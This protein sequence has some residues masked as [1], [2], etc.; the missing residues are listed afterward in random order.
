MNSKNLCFLCVVLISAS[1][2]C[3]DNDDRPDPIVPNK[4]EIL[5]ATEVTTQSAVLNGTI[6]L[7]D[8]ETSD[9]GFVYNTTSNVALLGYTYVSL[10]KA[11]SS[12]T[13][14]FELEELL[15]GTTYY[16]RAYVNQKGTTLY[17]PE[18]SFTTAE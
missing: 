10:G 16:F 9:C 8:I 7:G 14:S 18:Q 3:S 2:A 4:V 13:I 15:P 12:G 6:T 17:S 11:E 1:F 5:T